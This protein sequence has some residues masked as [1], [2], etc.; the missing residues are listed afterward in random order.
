MNHQ[1]VNLKALRNAELIQYLRDYCQILLQHDPSLLHVEPQHTALLTQI[2][3][4]EA[5]FKQ[6][7]S[8][9]LTEKIAELDAQRDAH[10]GGIFTTAT[11]M[12]THPDADIRNAALLL[13][14]KLSVYGTATEIAR[15]TLQG[16]TTTVHNLIHDLEHLPS[17]PEAI[18]TLGLTSWVAA[19]K[20]TNTTL[21]SDYLKRT[22]EIAALNPDKL[23]ELRIQAND[24][25]YALRDMLMAQA[26]VSGYVA[27]FPTAIA[28]VNALTNQYVQTLAVRAGI[29]SASEDAA[30]TDPVDL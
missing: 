15:Q 8:S 29:A 28:E 6:D 10:L 21:E 9:A 27:P 16:Q 11:G 22:A 17:L 25:F 24:L 23:K 18:S 19:L 14:D 4:L 13:L 7:L 12:S 20:T 26:L 5:I 1:F 3:A 30:P 2:A